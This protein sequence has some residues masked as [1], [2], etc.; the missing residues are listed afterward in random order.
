[1]KEEYFNFL[2][3]WSLPEEFNKPLPALHLLK[4]W[5]KT[6]LVICPLRFG[7]IEETNT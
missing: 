1:M 5:V 7:M 6:F 3:I 2:E 4:S